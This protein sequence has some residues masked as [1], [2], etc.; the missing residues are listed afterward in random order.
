MFSIKG[1]IYSFN[2]FKSL[3]GRA[4]IE[5]V[6]PFKRLRRLHAGVYIEKCFYF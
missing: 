2:D 6:L 3:R 4:Q 1:L 5:T